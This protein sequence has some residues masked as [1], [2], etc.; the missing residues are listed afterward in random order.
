MANAL[1]DFFRMGGY[2]PF[3]WGAYGVTALVMGGMALAAL[4]RTRRRRRELSR[5]QSRL[6]NRPENRETAR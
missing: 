2:G 6:E 1:T 4:L 5:L 3:V